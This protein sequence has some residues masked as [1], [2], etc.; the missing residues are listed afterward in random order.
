MRPVP[1]HVVD[2]VDEGAR[3][4]LAQP[5][6]DGGRLVDAQFEAADVS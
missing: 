6:L 4:G 2:P 5:G 1:Q 3:L